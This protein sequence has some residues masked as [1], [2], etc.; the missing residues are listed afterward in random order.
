MRSLII[1]ALLVSAGCYDNP[2]PAPDQDETTLVAEIIWD[3][4]QR[5][6]PAIKD[7]GPLLEIEWRPKWCIKEVGRVCADGYFNSDGRGNLKIICVWFGWSVHETALT[8]E[9]NHYRQQ[10]MK[11][12][13]S[14]DPTDAYL[15]QLRIVQE[16]NNYL[17]HYGY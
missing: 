1:I 12:D 11:E 5:F 17:A 4:L 16:I 3:Q 8:H 7:K 14:D 9:L 6:Y 15:E 13:V 2:R 10:I